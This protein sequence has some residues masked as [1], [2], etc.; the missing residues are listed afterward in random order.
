MLPGKRVKSDSQERYGYAGAVGTV[1]QGGYGVGATGVVRMPS[2]A[3][4]LVEKSK[5]QALAGQGLEERQSPLPLSWCE[6]SS[7]MCGVPDVSKN[8]EE[9]AAVSV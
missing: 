5:Y 8:E 6:G 3:S 2:L 7:G 4:S 1:S 9:A